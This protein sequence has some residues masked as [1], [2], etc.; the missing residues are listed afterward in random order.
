MPL[1]PTPG[2]LPDTAATSGDRVTDLIQKLVAAATAEVDSAAQRTRAQ[3]QIEISELHRTIARLRDD[4]QAERDRL[5]A[6]STELVLARAAASQLKEELEA[7]RHE[8]ACLAAT[9]ETV[10]LVISGIGPEV[11]GPDPTPPPTAHV[12]ESDDELADSEFDADLDLA[13]FQAGDPV[14]AAGQSLTA[15]DMPDRGAV[16]QSGATGHLAQL[17]A[18]I[19]EIYRSD[20]KS[21]E[22]T[23][24]VVTRLAANLAYARDAYARRLDSADGEDVTQFDRQVAALR[25]TRSGTPFGRHLALAFRVPATDRRSSDLQEEA[26]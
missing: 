5:E 7:A 13:E 19:E 3:A 9:L 18:Q 22:G 6:A 24:E 12:E 21:S 14:V 20:L 16:P 1:S 15:D 23:S 17:L 2:T 26:C 25:D 8:K 4:V 11:H 10:R